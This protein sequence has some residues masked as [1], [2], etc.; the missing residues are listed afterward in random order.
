[1][2]HTKLLAPGNPIDVDPVQSKLAQLHL[3]SYRT[4]RLSAANGDGI[5]GAGDR[6][7]CA[8]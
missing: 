8:H 4:I 1:M 5:R 2:P 6:R 7:W 3:S